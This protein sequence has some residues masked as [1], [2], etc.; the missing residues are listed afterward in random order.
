[1]TQLRKAEV[2]APKTKATS[3]IL[4]M[5][6]LANEYY[7]S[8]MVNC[9]IGD[10]FKPELKDKIFLL[11]KFSNTRYFAN[12]EAELQNMPEFHSSYSCGNEQEMFVFNVPKMYKKDYQLFKEG[13]YSKLSDVL[14]K[15]TLRLNRLGPESNIWGAFTKSDRLRKIQEERIGEQLPKDAEVISLPDMN[16]E[17]YKG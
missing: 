6:G 1:M 12:L 5:L 11:F 14:K 3:F 15:E 13:Q 7:G 8:C 16:V 17:I 4:P 10:V 9:Y 2:V